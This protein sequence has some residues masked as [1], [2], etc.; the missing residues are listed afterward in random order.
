M[1]AD[2]RLD[3]VGNRPYGLKE[4]IFLPWRATERLP[5]EKNMKNLKKVIHIWD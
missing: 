4:G 1:V 2:L 5:W 3:L